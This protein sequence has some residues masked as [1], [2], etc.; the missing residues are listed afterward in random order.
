MGDLWLFEKNSMTLKNY[1]VIAHN[2]NI[3]IKMEMPVALT[4]FFVRGKLEF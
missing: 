1:L 2:L 3:Q 4:L